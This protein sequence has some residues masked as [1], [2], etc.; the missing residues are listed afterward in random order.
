MY[1]SRRTLDGDRS[2]TFARS[3]SVKRFE[4]SQKQHTSSLVMMLT[5]L[6]L[7]HVR[8]SMLDHFASC[9]IRCRSLPSFTVLDTPLSSYI[10]YSS[11]LI[12]SYFVCRRD[13]IS[14]STDNLP[15]ANTE[16]RLCYATIKTNPY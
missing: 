11:P 7:L 10:S 15:S 6:L 12:L 5:R 1:A 2:H 14:H 8:E 16:H 3:V 13:R 4:E 9:A